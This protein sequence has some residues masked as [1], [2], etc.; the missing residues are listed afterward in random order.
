MQS[1][2]ENDNA[3]G[4]SIEIRWI[5]LLFIQITSQRNY[6]YIC[7]VQYK[8]TLWNRMLYNFLKKTISNLQINK[9]KKH[10]FFFTTVYI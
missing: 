9:H 3:F 1:S 2:N 10:F 7:G 4:T 5:I 8:Q 6:V